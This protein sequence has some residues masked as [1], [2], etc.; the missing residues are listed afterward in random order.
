MKHSKLPWRKLDCGTPDCWCACIEADELDDLGE[1]YVVISAG[2][3]KKEDID[4][5]LRACNNFRDL[6]G[7]LETI[8]E[9]FKNGNIVVHS[10]H[11]VSIAHRV[12]EEVKTALTK[13]KEEL[14]CSK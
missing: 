5:I 4:F 7:A 9:L 6:T 11:D 13:A 10:W 3:T 2:S 1:P 14:N 8:L 12:L